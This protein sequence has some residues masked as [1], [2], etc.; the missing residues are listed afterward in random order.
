M[1]YHR[2]MIIATFRAIHP[3]VLTVT[4]AR[5]EKL[6]QDLFETINDELESEAAKA[7]IPINKFNLSMLVYFSELS[8]SAAPVKRAEAACKYFKSTMPVP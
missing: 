7:G 2:N 1:N 6:D 5:L 8:Q 4:E 3:K